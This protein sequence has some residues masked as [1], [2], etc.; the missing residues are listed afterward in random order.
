MI[1][2]QFCQGEAN[3]PSSN[4]RSFVAVKLTTLIKCWCYGAKVT[5]SHLK[6]HFRA[7]QA[8]AQGDVADDYS[9][10]FSYPC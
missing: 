8:E 10:G 7:R 1:D 4:L 3:L 6:R 2:K 9:A 5:P